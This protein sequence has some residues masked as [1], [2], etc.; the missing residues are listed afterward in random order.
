MTNLGGIMRT[1]LE[2]KEGNIEEISTFIK[3]TKF[4][5]FE[6]KVI[7]KAK[8]CLLDFIGS[9]LA[10]SILESGRISSLFA[11]DSSRNHEA[12]ILAT[13]DKVSIR[14][15]AFANG[16][17]ASA[18]DIDDGHRMA[19]GHP[20]GVIIP[21]ALAVAEKSKISGKKFIE[22][23]VVGYE[24]GIRMGEILATQSR[25]VYGSG[26]WACVGA[27]TS[28]AKI[29]DLKLDNIGNALGIAGTFAPIAPLL[30]DISSGRMSM[31]KESMGWG[32]MVGVS[33]A[34][35]ASMGFTGPSSVID[36]SLSSLGKLGKNFEIKN[37]YFK[38]YP[39][40]RWCHSAIDGVIEIM[41]LHHIRKDD[42][43]RVLITTFSH[44]A[45]LQERR[46]RSINIAQ[47]SLPF[48]VALA[49]LEGKVSVD[50]FTKEKLLN[51]KVL[52]YMKRIQIKSDLTLNKNFPKLIPSIVEIETFSK[53]SYKI[54]IDVP[55]GNPANPLTEKELVTKF[56]KL[57]SKRITSKSIKGILKRIREMES[58][59]NVAELINVFEYI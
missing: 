1:Q 57:A 7:N 40:C 6:Q 26:R 37:V 16:V 58:L 18:F 2:R 24:I 47:Y 45:E 46:P 34:F 14:D 31:T 33:S 59:E 36:F 28:V 11:V 42:V 30:N 44:A 56:K 55:K 50:Q 19:V 5:N 25:E 27:A 10:G 20:G 29:F 4:E 51:R 52:E 54:K 41:R 15:A 32:A 12:T 22:A 23:I 53:S 48:V 13:G 38:L 49:I 3:M 17:M 43:K 9:A 8:E 39:C 21:A 35:L